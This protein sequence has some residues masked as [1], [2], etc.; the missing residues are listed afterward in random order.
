MYYSITYYPSE[1][2]GYDWAIRIVTNGRNLNKIKHNKVYV[3]K[4]YGK[5][6][7]EVTVKNDDREL[8]MTEGKRLINEVVE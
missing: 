5:D 7:Y 2:G 8:A 6:W 1:W 4:Y 3:G